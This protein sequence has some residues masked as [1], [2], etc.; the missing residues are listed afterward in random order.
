M[1]YNFDPELAAALAA[2]P[3]F[4]QPP[5]PPPLGVSQ[6][7]WARQ[8]AKVALAPW[9]EHFRAKLPDSSQYIV[10]DKRVPVEGPSGEITV[11]YI[12][13]SGGDEET[14]PVLVWWHGGGWAIGDLDMDDNH[15]RTIAVELK[16][17]IVNVDYRLSPEFQFPTPFEDCYTALKWVAENAAELQI[18]L[19]K[20][21]LVGGDSAGGN[22]SAAIALKARDD[23][24]F[25]GRQ[26]T[27]QYLREPA[28]AAPGGHPE[29][30][31]AEIK[32]FDK[33]T[34]TPLLN[35]ELVMRY[36]EA[37]APPPYDLRV[38]PIGASSH[39]GL[40]PAFIQIQE[41]DPV[42][43]DGPL[44]ERVLREAGVPVKLI[45]YAGCLHGF[46]YSFPTISA[47]VKLDRDTRDGLR[48]LLSQS[49]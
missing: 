32:S 46:H 6:W 37:Y 13:P 3:A 11:R 20:G 7:E 18:D 38:S 29:K 10:A 36:F 48:W 30:Y 44:Y 1:G 5:P 4:T 49:K 33:Y 14:F 22:M 34:D 2:N 45:E 23:P 41:F 27:G 28:V 15:L 9:A 39:A 21:F 24:F 43:D 47:A 12:R 8:L 16:L 35:R 42:H 25:A 40:P 31:K 26:L 19:K 17:A